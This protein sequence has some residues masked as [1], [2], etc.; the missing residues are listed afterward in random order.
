M[1]ILREE[2]RLAEAV[3]VVN[4]KSSFTDE[5]VVVIGE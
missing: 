4:E 2:L 1:Q 5:V 3:L